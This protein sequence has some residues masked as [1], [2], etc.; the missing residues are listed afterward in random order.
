M[1]GYIQIYSGDEQGGTSAALGL[2]LR[3]AGAGFK[4]FIARFNQK[5]DTNDMK[6]LQRFADLI[7]VEQYG[8]GRFVDGRPLPEDT[9]AARK[10]LKRVT[11]ILAAG[12]HQLVVLDRANSAVKDSLFSEQD[13]LHVMLAKP[14]RVELV[15]TGQGASPRIIERA[16]LVTEVISAKPSMASD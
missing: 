12:E 6:A 1:K 15:I 11:S 16:D 7:T 10:G 14:N 3:A 8:L 5:Q 2:S 9:A 13:L 4:I